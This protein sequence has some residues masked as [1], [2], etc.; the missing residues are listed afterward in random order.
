[1]LL[2]ACASHVRAALEDDFVSLPP[3]LASRVPARLVFSEGELVQCLADKTANRCILKGTRNAS[4]PG[5]VQIGQQQRHSSSSGSCCWASDTA[6]SA[7]RCNNFA[8]FTI[9][10][11]LVLSC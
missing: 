7:C 8:S 9:A 4:A 6:L 1:M 10:T 2:V 3:E 11:L 5:M